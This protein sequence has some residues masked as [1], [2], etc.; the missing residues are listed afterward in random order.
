M[1]EC[2]SGAGRP[3]GEAGRRSGGPA[4]RRARAGRPG[5]ARLAGC[6]STQA[7]RTDSM[8]WTAAASAAAVLAELA[9]RGAACAAGPPAA[10]TAGDGAVEAAAAA[11]G[12]NGSAMAR[13]GL[14]ASLLAGQFRILTGPR[15]VGD[16][17]GVGRQGEP[18]AG[19]W[20][21]EDRSI[22]RP[23]VRS[24]ARRQIHASL[25]AY[26]SFRRR[27]SAA[28][29]QPPRLPAQSVPG[30]GLG[31]QLSGRVPHHHVI[32]ESPEGRRG[33]GRGGRDVGPCLSAAYHNRCGRTMGVPLV[34]ILTVRA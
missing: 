14:P 28:A 32:A 12:R 30:R 20:V 15:G 19:C 33:G 1:A 11:H 17:V 24:K 21:P 9:G 2:R 27:S 22:V 10:A 13:R 16:G 5:Q 8:A 23:V 4:C 29:T 7:G 25:A 3:P 6:R 31:L 18:G 26:A 34:H